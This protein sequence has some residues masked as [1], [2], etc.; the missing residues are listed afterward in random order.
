MCRGRLG[1]SMF[2]NLLE[3]LQSIEL[4]IAHREVSLHRRTCKMARK[5]TFLLGALGTSVYSLYIRLS[6]QDTQD[7]FSPKW[8]CRVGEQGALL[9]QFGNRIPGRVGNPGQIR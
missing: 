6:L 1:H 4:G 7:V 2:H 5:G 9:F 8:K 3:Y